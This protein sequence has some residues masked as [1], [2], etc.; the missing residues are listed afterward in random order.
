MDAY[1]L[2]IKARKHYLKGNMFRAK[3]TTK[4][5]NLVHNSYIPF[6]VEIGENSK[7]AYGGIG[8]VLHG[9]CKIGK[10]CTIGQGCT[11]G[12]RTGHGGPPIIGDNVYISAG[13]RLLGGFQVGNNVVIGAN[14]VVIENVPDNCVVAGVPAKII[15]TNIDKWKNESI[16]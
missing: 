6:T 3:I 7:F 13:A 4:L 15:S 1:K 5:N 9:K 2:Y 11:I 14:A 10:N 12:G 16:I 8:V